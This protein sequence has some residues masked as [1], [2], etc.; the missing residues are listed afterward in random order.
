M[1]QSSDEGLEKDVIKV[2]V[3]LMKEKDERDMMLAENDP[4]SNVET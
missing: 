2:K 3:K 1:S 4:S